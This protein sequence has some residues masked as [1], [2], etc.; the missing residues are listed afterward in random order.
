MILKLENEFKLYEKEGHSLSILKSF[1]VKH[2]SSSDYES[3]DNDRTVT[4]K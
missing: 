2:S 1:F 4:V 3:S